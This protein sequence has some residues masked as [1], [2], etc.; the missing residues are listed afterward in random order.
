MATNN[1]PN[2]IVGHAESNRHKWTITI[3]MEGNDD[4]AV[5]HA[6]IVEFYSVKAIARLLK[7]KNPHMLVRIIEQ[8]C[9]QTYR[10]RVPRRKGI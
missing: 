9:G 5:T 3:E 6:Q 2:C 7:D 10:V 4:H 1:K 8:E